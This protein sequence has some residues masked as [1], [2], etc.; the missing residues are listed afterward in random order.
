M[1]V[2]GMPLGTASVEN[3]SLG[4]GDNSFPMTAIANEAAIVELIVGTYKTGVL[5]VD[6]VASSIVYKGQHDPWYEQAF[7]AL[8]LRVDL[9]MVPA[10]QDLGL[11]GAFGLGTPPSA[12]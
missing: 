2:N 3:V 7:K 8:P 9:N 5:P 1:T 12:R 10:L 11:A 4:P 6:I